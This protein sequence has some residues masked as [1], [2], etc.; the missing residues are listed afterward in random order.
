M[1]NRRAVCVWEVYDVPEFD[2]AVLGMRNT[3]TGKCLT[4]SLVVHKQVLR[5]VVCL[6]FCGSVG[7]ITCQMRSHVD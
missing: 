1:H 7:I 6:P 2:L 3:D 4:G 5:R